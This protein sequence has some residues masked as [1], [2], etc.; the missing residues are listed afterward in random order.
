MTPE[1]PQGISREGNLVLVS[2]DARLNAPT[3]SALEAFVSDARDRVGVLVE[4]SLSTAPPSPA[5][6]RS[7]REGL[8]DPSIIAGL[9]LVHDGERLRSR[10][11]RGVL[12]GV[13]RATKTL[14]VRVFDSPR[15]AR[16]WLRVQLDV[17]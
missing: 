12:E 7:M 10:L 3:L 13:A 14:P 17:A 2:P 16:A 5:L 11:I 8:L 4:V 1:L 9:A 15:T 6:R